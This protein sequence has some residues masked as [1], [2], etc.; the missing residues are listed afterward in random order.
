MQK[1]HD[2]QINFAS[3]LL[4]L[5]G[6]WVMLV[7]LFTSVSGGTLWVQEITGVAFLVF[8]AIQMAVESTIPSWITAIAAI[9]LLVM[10]FAVTTNTTVFWNELVVGVAALVFSAFDGYEVA[11]DQLQHSLE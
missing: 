9:A 5:L 10:P 1:T 7:P 11:Q 4:M 8:G 3:S 6:A 2:L